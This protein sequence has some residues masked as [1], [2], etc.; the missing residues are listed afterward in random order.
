M[1]PFYIISINKTMRA[2]MSRC[3]NTFRKILNIFR[4]DRRTTT[5]SKPAAEVDTE[6][7]VAVKPDSW[8]DL[9]V[10]WNQNGIVPHDIAE[11]R[12]CINADG[13]NP[14]AIK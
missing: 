7:A 4:R 13:S 5:A 8:A 11:V 14:D 2:R 6:Y 1:L 3:L 9:T 12:R 10:G